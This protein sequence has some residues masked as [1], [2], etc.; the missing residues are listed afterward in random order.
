MGSSTVSFSSFVFL[1]QDFFEYSQYSKGRVQTS[2]YSTITGSKVI[3][4]IIN[5]IMN[6]KEKKDS[7]VINIRKKSF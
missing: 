1:E 5:F 2:Q 6:L 4:Y 7:H 3:V